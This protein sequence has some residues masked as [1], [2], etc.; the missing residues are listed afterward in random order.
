M[1]IQLNMNKLSTQNKTNEI[2]TIKI[3]LSPSGNTCRYFHNW[4][5]GFKGKHTTSKTTRPGHSLESLE[6]LQIFNDISRSVMHEE[7]YQ[8]V[9]NTI[10]PTL[11]SGWTNIIVWIACYHWIKEQLSVF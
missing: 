10:I 8:K 11:K 2:F 5:T 3:N 1:K 9:D 6:D 4:I 7:I